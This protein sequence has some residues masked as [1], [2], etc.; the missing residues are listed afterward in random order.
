MFPSNKYKKFWTW[1]KKESNNFYIHETIP[2]N[3]LNKL[4]NE[5]HKINK[6]LTFEFGPK[7]T[8]RKFI[9]SADGIK[10]AFN[11]VEKLVE[12]KPVMENWE[13][14]KF[15]QR[16]DFDNII[17]IN[18]ISLYPENIRY[19]LFPY[20]NRIGLILFIKGFLSNEDILKQMGYLFLD[21]ALG[22]YD[23]EMKIDGI[24]FC[25]YNDEYFEQS[26]PAKTL[27][28]DFDKL[29]NELKL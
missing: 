23:V 14:L 19:V 8:K 16:K 24:K 29:C 21:D 13:T 10:G 5:L 4:H 17:T 2:E 1:F 11:D 6:Y 25:D 12:E 18:D 22:E 9:I 28:K 3:I 20:N 15:R 26:L 7:T 27:R